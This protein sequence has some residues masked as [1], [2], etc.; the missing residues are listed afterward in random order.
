MTDKEIIYLYNGGQREQA[1]NHIVKDYSERLYLHIRRFVYSHDDA[2]DLVQEVFIKIWAAL[3]SFR[4]G[5]AAF[6]VDIQDCHERSPELP[7]QTEDPRTDISGLCRLN[8][9]QKT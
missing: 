4:G 3:P 8:P 1:F 2:N 5:R 7:S 9:R 6:Y